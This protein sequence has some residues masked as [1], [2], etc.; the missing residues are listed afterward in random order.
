MSE[1]SENLESDPKSAIRIRIAD[2]LMT[3][4]RGN[5]SGEQLRAASELVTKAARILEE[6]VTVESVKA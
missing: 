6:G 2:I 5:C 3:I 1:F 4:L